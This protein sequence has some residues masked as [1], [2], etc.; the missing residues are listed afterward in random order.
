MKWL[1]RILGVLVALLVIAFLIFRTPDTDPAEMRAKYGGAPSQFVEISSGVSVHL[2]DEGPRDATAIMLL[3]GSNDDLHTWDEW[4]EGLRETYR[5]IRFDQIG[6]GLT[7]PDPDGDYSRANFA[8]DIREVAD[9]LGLETFVLGGNSMGG[10]HALAFAL[11]YPERLEGLILVDASGIPLEFRTKTKEQEEDS[12]NIGFAIASTPGLNKIAEQ[13][14]PRALVKQSLEQSVSVQSVV[15]EQA[16]DRY[17]ELLRYPGNRAATM[18]RFTNGYDPL[19]A[20]EIAS[21]AVPSLIQWGDEDRLIPLSAGEWL[22]ATMPN[23]QMKVY[24]EIGHLPHKE[25]PGAT[26][27]DVKSWIETLEPA[28]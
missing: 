24:T 23:S 22:N 2:R 3:H 12:G 11:Q 27:K 1:L 6:H 7:G 20:Q 8:E 4:A 16:V 17:W 26:L 10:K 19:T 5:I 13:I 18:A 28:G 15:T 25:I 21:I 14:T 9:A